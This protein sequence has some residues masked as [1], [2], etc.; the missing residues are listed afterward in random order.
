MNN[1][2]APTIADAAGVTPRSS[3]DGRSL[4]PLVQGERGAVGRRTMLVELPPEYLPARNNP[5][6]YMIRSKDP[7]LT[8]DETGSL[9]LVYAQTL[10][11]VRAVQTDLELYDLSVDPLQLSSLHE[12]RASDRRKQRERLRARLESMK[13]CVADGCRA[14]ED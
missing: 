13:A 3:V 14:L 12:S 8:L 4:M 10:D 6:Y 2:W 7:A 5:P 1:D 9:V 11:P